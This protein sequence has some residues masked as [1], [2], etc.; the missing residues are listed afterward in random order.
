MFQMAGRDLFP[1]PNHHEE[2]DHML[3]EL[4]SNTRPLAWRA[5]IVK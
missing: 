1:I 3:E 5:L 2:T 4:Y